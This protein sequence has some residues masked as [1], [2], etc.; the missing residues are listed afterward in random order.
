MRTT[1]ARW[2]NSAALRLPRPIEELRLGPGQQVEMMVE[3]GEARLQAGAR[4]DASW[5]RLMAE[6][7]RHRLGASPRLVDWGASRRPEIID[8]E[9]SAGRSSPGPNGALF[10]QRPMNLPEAGDIHWAD[11][12]TTLGTEQAEPAAGACSL[13]ARLQMRARLESF[14][15]PITS[16]P[17]EWPVVVPMPSLLR[18]RGVILCDQVRAIDR[19]ARL[20]GYIERLPEESSSIAVRRVLGAILGVRT[21]TI[22]T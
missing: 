7:D 19:R 9:S 5:K 2:G 18:T 20:F 10:R 17:V 15:C 12:G 6:A 8:D 11:F 16:R 14:L 3:G 22:G 1:I 21:Q 4:P 13:G